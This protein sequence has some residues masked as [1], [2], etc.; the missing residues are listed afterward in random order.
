MARKLHVEISPANWKRVKEYLETYNKDP[1]RITP[2][3]KP[4]HVIN[5]ALAEYLARVQG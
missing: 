4:A 2:R 5:M 1:Q 3:F